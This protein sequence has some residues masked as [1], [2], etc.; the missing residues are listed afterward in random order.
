MAKGIPD[1]KQF[2][3]KSYRFSAYR[4]MFFWLDK[5]KG[6][7]KPRKALPACL[8]RIT[9]YQYKIFFLIFMFFSYVYKKLISRRCIYW[10]SAFI[11]GYQGQK[12]EKLQQS[13][14]ICIDLK[15]TLVYGV[16]DH[17]LCIL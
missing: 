15:L 9:H 16:Y 4:S 14:N 12:A 2:D 11:S 13:I 6:S 1:T 17:I 3:N 10:F 7:K 5:K 8:G